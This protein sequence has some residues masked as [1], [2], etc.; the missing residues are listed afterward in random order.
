[1]MVKAL[2]R[3]HKVFFSTEL[4]YEKGGTKEET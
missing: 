3:G 2:E 1:M 4:K